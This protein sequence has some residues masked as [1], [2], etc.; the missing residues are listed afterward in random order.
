[1]TI[2]RPA[3]ILSDQI[4]VFITECNSRSNAKE[5]KCLNSVDKSAKMYKK[6]SGDSI[7][8]DNHRQRSN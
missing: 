1:M 4:T 6:H 5:S 8:N 2:P 3:Q 7:L